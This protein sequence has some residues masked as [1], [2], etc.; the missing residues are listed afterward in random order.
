[1]TSSPLL[2]LDEISKTYSSG[3]EILTV[4]DRVSLE[5]VE[6]ETVAIL[7][8]SGSGKSTLLN[9]IGTLDR[10]TGGKFFFNNE[11][12]ST[13]N[14]EQLAQIRNRQIGFVFQS[15][16]LL[17]QCTALENVLV[18]TLAAEKSS[19][20]GAKERAMALLQ[21]V[22]LAARTHHFPGQLSGG[23]RQRIALVRALIN[24]PKL[25]LADEPTGSLDRTSAS[26]L[27]ELLMELNQEQGVTV[28]LV[29]HAQ[30][31]ANRMKRQLELKDGNLV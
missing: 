13:Q 12:L 10:P 1:M 28:I 23:E 5:I 25:L 19:R 17:P 15:H 24:R 6:K 27:A 21:R 16:H 31:L 7:G 14:E 3:D 2:R 9:I 4:L 20:E 22:G 29:T 8:P 11:D 26:G 18:P 30:D